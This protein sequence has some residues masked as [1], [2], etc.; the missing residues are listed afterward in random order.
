M[1][2]HDIE[3]ETNGVKNG[4]INLETTCCWVRGWIKHIYEMESSERSYTIF[5]YERL[6]PY[7]RSLG[8]TS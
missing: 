1:R 6:G 4:C 3:R 5:L 7:L 8:T 2:V